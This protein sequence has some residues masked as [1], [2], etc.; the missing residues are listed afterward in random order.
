[1]FIVLLFKVTINATFCRKLS[2]VFHIII[3]KAIT[4]HFNLC[5]SCIYVLV[6]SIHICFNNSDCC[7]PVLQGSLFLHIHTLSDSYHKWKENY[8]CTADEKTITVKTKLLTLPKRFC[9]GVCSKNTPLLL[10][11]RSE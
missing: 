6:T 3:T 1:M 11:A 5:I 7:L 10:N 2:V 9:N 4:I 8:N